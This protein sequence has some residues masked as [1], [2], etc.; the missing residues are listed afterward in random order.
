VAGRFWL[1]TVIGSGSDLD[2]YRAKTQDV[3]ALNGIGCVAHLPTKIDGTPRFGYCVTRAANIAALR[4]DP[5]HT[6][7]PT[8]ATTWAS[9]TPTQQTT[10]TQFCSS[11][12][13][14]SYVPA[15]A[16]TFLDII[17][18]L[19]RALEGRQDIDGATALVD[20]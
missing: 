4:A 7:L 8:L 13:G 6:L 19:I 1:T 18:A 20:A 9:L 5:D 12:F 16:D 11:H 14:L 3:A 2:P 15:P 17:R 10:F